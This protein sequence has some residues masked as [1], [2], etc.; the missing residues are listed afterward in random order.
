MGELNFIGYEDS[1]DPLG[2]FPVPELRNPACFSF[3]GFEG[4]ID[5]ENPF[6]GCLSLTT[7]KAH[8]KSLFNDMKKK[9]GIGDES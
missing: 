7:P 2:G 8:S 6:A 3:A 5:L 1:D 9:L 4:R